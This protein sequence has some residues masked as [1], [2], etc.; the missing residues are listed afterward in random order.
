M[1]REIREIKNR[2]RM[3]NSRNEHKEYLGIKPEKEL[4]KDE[5]L[6]GIAKIFMNARSDEN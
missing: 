1:F 5:L 3:N 4:S 6:D 2:E